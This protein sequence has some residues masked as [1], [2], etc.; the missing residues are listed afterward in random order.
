MKGNECCD[1]NKTRDP[2]GT[3]IPYG[4]PVSRNPLACPDDPEFPQH[5]VFRDHNSEKVR[6]RAGIMGH[7]PAGIYEVVFSDVPAA[8]WALQ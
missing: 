8:E 7:S 2:S 1:G 6:N 5:Q 3:G 4:I